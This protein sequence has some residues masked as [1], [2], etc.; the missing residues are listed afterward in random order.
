MVKLAFSGSIKDALQEH[1]PKNTSGEVVSLSVG[2]SLLL[3]IDACKKNTHINMTTIDALYK[4]YLEGIKTSGER[5]F[6]AGLAEEL[7]KHHFIV[8]FDPHAINEDPTRRYFET[9]LAYQIITHSAEASKKTLS[10]EALKNHTA[11]LKNRLLSLPD[12]SDEFRNKTENILAGKTN[13]NPP[14]DKYQ[15]EYA[16]LIDKL[17][18]NDFYGLPADVCE[19]LCEIARSTILATLNTQMDKTMPVDV[20]SDSIFTMGMDGRGRIVKKDHDN[21]RT[22]AK[23]LM[24]SASPLPMYDDVVNPAKKSPEKTQPEK[25]ASTSVKK[26]NDDDLANSIP[27]YEPSPKNASYST[28]DTSQNENSPLYLATTETVSSQVPPILPADPRELSPFQRSADQSTYMLES[29]WSQLLFSRQTQVYSNGIS[30]TTLAQVRNLITQKRLGNN[31]YSTNLQEYMTLFASLMLYN[32]GG[33]SFFEI[34][35]VMKLPLFRELVHKQSGIANAIKQDTLMY[36]FLCADQYPAFE[37]AMQLTLQYSRVILSKKVMNAQLLNQTQ[38]KK[39]PIA[40]TKKES[41]PT[42][43]DKAKSLTDAVLQY[44][45]K[46]FRAYVNK[47]DPNS[48]NQKN[49]KG[50][51]ALMIAAQT[52]RYN[53]VDILIGAGASVDMKIE[54]KPNEKEA[55]GEGYSALDLAIKAEK[56]KTVEILIKHSP[57]VKPPSVA[58]NKKDSF[59]VEF[60][61]LYL[62]ARQNDPRILKL[63]LD[64]GQYRQDQI[65]HAILAAVKVE[66]LI[67]LEMLTQHLAKIKKPKSFAIDKFFSANDF[68]YNLLSD[69]IK[70]GNDKLLRLIASEKSLLPPHTIEKHLK[71]IFANKNVLLEGQNTILGLLRKVNNKKNIN[72]ILN[73]A[74]RNHNFDLAVLAIIHGADPFSIK[75]NQTT[76]TKFNAYLKQEPIHL[77]KQVLSDKHEMIAKRSN[78]IENQIPKHSNSGRMRLI[79]YIVDF[80]RATLPKKFHFLANAMTPKDGSS[81]H[82]THIANSMLTI[83]KTTNNTDNTEPP[84][85]KTTVPIT[86][87][88]SPPKSKK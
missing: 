21:V 9:H 23:G 35:E 76:L 20:Y 14:L 68:E 28:S 63:V 16:E 31:A 67:S 81:T 24:K 25:A 62:A 27:H 2:E 32:S 29:A 83:F 15:L 65:Q 72:I 53:H 18:R 80:L 44:D 64:H 52:G 79:Q 59:R 39:S 85:Q 73:E 19:K 86:P 10:I 11:N 74:L 70:T 7:R 43:H 78:E 88:N 84:N 50:W 22:T 17:I 42:T 4:L 1:L 13:A 5:K 60:L 37:K 38:A 71:S 36:K 61:T 77:I 66:N 30:S 82:K 6:V 69:A 3:L 8:N 45:A 48:I 34:F 58:A 12:L 57:N 26:T 47:I 51:T 40:S 56:F 55:D 41:K 49:K 46:K 33:H 54:R 75:C 87:K